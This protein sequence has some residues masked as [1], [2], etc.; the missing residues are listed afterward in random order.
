MPFCEFI[1]EID[2]FGKEP[3]FYIKG[4]SKQETLF[5]RIFTSLFIIIY[6][7]FFSYKVFRITQRVDIT[8]YDSYSNTDEIPTIKITQENFTL[9]FAILDEDGEPFIDETIYYPE[10]FFSDA[11]A[12][13]LEEIKIEICNPDKMSKEY[14]EIFDESEIGNYYCLTDINYSLRPFLNYIRIEIFPCENTDEDDD[15]CESKE[16]IEGYLEDKLFM[17]YFQDIMLTPL[18]FNHPVKKRINYL[19]T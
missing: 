16:F 11:E 1:K 5:G 19:N 10:A 15:Y 14:K 13:E 7:I 17:I 8:F 18:D 9:V 4:K 12:E 6:I 3:E 2:L